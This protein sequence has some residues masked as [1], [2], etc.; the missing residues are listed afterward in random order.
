MFDPK[1]FDTNKTL[2]QEC[3]KLIGDHN[4]SSHAKV[5]FNEPTIEYRF[6]SSSKTKSDPITDAIGSFYEQYTSQVYSTKILKTIL[7][8]TNYTSESLAMNI[9]LS[10]DSI[11]ALLSKLSITREKL[12]ECQARIVDNLHKQVDAF[13]QYIESSVSEDTDVQNVIEVVFTCMAQKGLSNKVDVVEEDRPFIVVGSKI[14]EALVRRALLTEELILLIKSKNDILKQTILHNPSIQVHHV[15]KLQT[16]GLIPNEGPNKTLSEVMKDLF[17]LEMPHVEYLKDAVGDL[18]KVIQMSVADTGLPTGLIVH[19][20]PNADMYFDMTSLFQ[21]TQALGSKGVDAAM[22][23]AFDLIR[24]GTDS[25][26]TKSSLL[27]INVDSG[28]TQLAYVLWTNNYKTFKFR[29]AP[30]DKLMISKLLRKSPSPTVE[31]YNSTF[32]S[33]MKDHQTND[34]INFNKVK[35]MSFTQDGSEDEFLNK[36]QTELATYISN[37]L[38]G[39]KGGAILDAVSGKFS[40]GL[41]DVLE[42]MKVDLGVLSQQLPPHCH[43]IYGNM[44][45]KIVSKIKKELAALSEIDQGAIK[46]MLYV[47]VK[48]NDNIYSRTI[49]GYYLHLA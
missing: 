34:A 41:F 22:V 19:V 10:S 31:A 45:S 4:A 9:D 6:I 26:E 18:Q 20:S 5:V 40:D 43:I 47:V 42:T 49:A 46:T 39:L 11:M 25:S 37:R 8:S 36:L 44:S 13:I 23:Q 16:F 27:T 30:I 3:R 48:T 1:H 33:L 15:N 12:L 21:V 24:H 28:S 2:L 29:E 14:I 35:Y 38:G 32:E 17:G 7:G